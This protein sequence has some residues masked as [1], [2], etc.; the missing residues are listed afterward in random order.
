MFI[1]TSTQSVLSSVGRRP[2]YL[3][4]DVLLIE[5]HRASVQAAIC[6][7]LKDQQSYQFLMVIPVLQVSEQHRPSVP[8]RL[9]GG[10][11]LRALYNTRSQPPATPNDHA[12]PDQY[13]AHFK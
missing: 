1:R 2:S 10:G 12:G 4:N 5:H 3:E 11:G 6:L 13:T 8:F 7:H 9:G